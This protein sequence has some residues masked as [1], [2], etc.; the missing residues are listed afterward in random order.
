VKYRFIGFVFIV[1]VALAFS[2]FSLVLQVSA[3]EDSPTESAA[4]R[5]VMAQSYLKNIQKP[6]DL[7]A[8][9]DRLQAYQYISQRLTVFVERLERN[10]QPE[11]ANLRAN[12]ER[13]NTS[14]TLFKDDYETYDQTR[15]AVVSVKDCRTN[16]EDFS[17]KL[18]VAREKR[19]AVSHDVE[20]LQSI[21]S[22]N[23]KSQLD[24]LYQQLLVSGKSGSTNE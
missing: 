16:F 12:L 5:C 15:E 21:L 8:R 1:T 19:V 2:S 22:T 13:L 10:N 4:D 18:A 3:Q 6:R 23:V 17:T 20:L 9:V 24:S 7:R 14:I 11:A